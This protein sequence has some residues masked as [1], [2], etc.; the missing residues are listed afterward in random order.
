MLPVKN[1]YALMMLLLGYAMAMQYND[2]DPWFW[3][4][5]YLYA[6]VVTICGYLQKPVTPK[7]AIVGALGYIGY[8][9]FSWPQVEGSWVQVEE[10]RETMG[11]MVCAGWMIILW[12]HTRSKST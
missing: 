10:G 9:I 1:F 4:A 3:V 7:L 12:W 8:M 6:F 11:L 2:P 5:L